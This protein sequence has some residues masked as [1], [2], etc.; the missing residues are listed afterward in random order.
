MQK[1]TQHSPAS[2]HSMHD[3]VQKSMTMIAPVIAYSQL[4]K[5]QATHK[6][7]ASPQSVTDASPRRILYNSKTCWTKF[8]IPDQLSTSNVLEYIVK[9]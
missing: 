6:A 9:N 8:Q 3:S 7:T 2:N 1:H 4:R 5:V